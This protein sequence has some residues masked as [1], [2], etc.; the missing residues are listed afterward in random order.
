MEENNPEWEKTVK[1]EIKA[2]CQ[3]I[4][5]KTH[6]YVSETKTD[7]VCMRENSFYVDTVRAFRDRRY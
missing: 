3:R 7:V 2:Y 5:K 4:Y 1:A 6:V